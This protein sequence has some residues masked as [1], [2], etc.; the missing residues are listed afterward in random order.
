LAQAARA[1]F[2]LRLG[3]SSE[4]AAK[5]LT[6]INEEPA[7]EEVAGLFSYYKQQFNR[8]TIPGILH[9]FSTHPPLLRHMMDLAEEMLF[10]DGHLSRREKEMIAT[11]V[12]AQNHC[13]YCAKSHG[14]FLYEICGSQTLL[15]A[16]MQCD[17]QG[18]GLQGNEVVL[19]EFAQKV[20]GQSQAVDRGDVER[21]MAAGWS[22]LQIAEA[23]HISALFACFNRIANAFGLEAQ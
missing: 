19:L 23:I 12:S 4:V 7:S 22:E 1:L 15:A 13:P 3:W 18:A 8:E 20:N 16:M 10:V 14:S 17:L 6:F 21:L 5:N 9:S 2:N 11:L